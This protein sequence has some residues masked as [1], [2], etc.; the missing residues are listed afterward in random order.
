[1]SDKELLERF[2]MV[3]FDLM[4]DYIDHLK[5]NRE[6]AEALVAILCGVH[7]GLGAWAASIQ[8]DALDAWLKEVELA[9]TPLTRAQG[10]C[11][12]EALRFVQKAG[13][14]AGRDYLGQEQV[15]SYSHVHPSGVVLKST[16]KVVW[17]YDTIANRWLH[18]TKVKERVSV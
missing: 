4:V 1:M 18:P 11:L 13:T 15:F 14:F 3:K 2:S 10:E 9:G 12:A 5:R 17:F 6:S 16:G 7:V 8:G